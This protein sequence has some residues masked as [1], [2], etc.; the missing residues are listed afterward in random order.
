[1]TSAAVSAAVA[2]TT[3][4]ATV[5]TTIA[6]TVAAFRESRRKI[7]EGDVERCNREA[8]RETENTENSGEPHANPSDM[9]R[10]AVTSRSLMRPIHKDLIDYLLSI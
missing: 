10:S 9:H 4:T 3:A 7:G 5:A 1:M 8:R 6:T 2:T